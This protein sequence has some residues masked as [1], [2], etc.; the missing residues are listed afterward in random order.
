MHTVDKPN[1][2]FADKV[3]HSP[4][5]QKVD[6]Q[7]D[8]S[9]R[10][11]HSLGH[12]YAVVAGAVA[13]VAGLTLIA[14]PAS[15]DTTD[16]DRPRMTAS[17]YD[18]GTNWSGFGEP[19]NGG[20]L[21][22]DVDDATDGVTI[23]LTGNLYINNNEDECANLTV[24]YHDADGGY[25]GAHSTGEGCATDGGLNSFPVDLRTPSSWAPNPD[26][27]HLHLTLNHRINWNTWETMSSQTWYNNG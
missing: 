21:T 15:A 6:S 27:D 11:T 3:D 9:S 13:L 1:P 14:S 22:W 19:F 10:S 8:G 7:A 26:I 12:R 4:S 5:G 24:L 20:T 16:T 17:G 2:A 18:F 25:E 23:R